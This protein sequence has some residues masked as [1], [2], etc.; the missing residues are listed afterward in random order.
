MI[1]EKQIVKLYQKRIQQR[2]DADGWSFYFSPEDFEGLACERFSFLNG[3]GDTLCAYVYYYGEKD[4][5]HPV[6]FDHG[7]GCGHRAYL[8]DIEYLASCGFTV[9]T[10]DHTGCATSGGE[11]ICGLSQ[12]L[13]D[14]DAFLTHLEASA[15]YRDA[16]FRV[17]GHSWGGYSTYNIAAYHKTVTHAV[18][19][20]GFRSVRAMLTDQLKGLLKYYINAVY[21][22]ELD[23]NPR[24]ASSDAC[25]S[26]VN[27][28]VKLYAVHS[29]DDPIVS[30]TTHFQS[31]ENQ[32]CER[33]NT[34]F[35]SYHDRAHNPYNT[36]R[37]VELLSDFFTKRGMQ[38]KTKKDATR[39]E[40]QEFLS[41]FDFYAIT[42]P[43]TELWDDVCTF[44]NT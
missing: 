37:A 41:Q 20:S 35:L 42:E 29:I 13:A 27:S 12:S 8:R 7:M 30:Y 5:T 24:Y 10:Y 25:D 6:V 4:S 19:I 21:A 28:G 9:L 33:E 14:L 23:L 11:H 38:V 16:T 34:V 32:L 40:K 18:P 3:Q 44:L 15:E 22:S 31:L 39:Q 2:Q 17:V 1:F 36:A 26:I 43:N